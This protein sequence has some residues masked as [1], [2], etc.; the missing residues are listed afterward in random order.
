MRRRLAFALVA[1]GDRIIDR[2]YQR[3]V[4]AGD[5]LQPRWYDRYATPL[6]R[7]G[8]RVHFEAGP[9]RMAR[10]GWWG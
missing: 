2:S 1:V 7:L 3:Y 4:D 5:V 10:A 8:C 9:R 6:A